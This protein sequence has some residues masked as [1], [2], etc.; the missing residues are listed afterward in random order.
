MV[1]LLFNYGN[2]K[3]K[4]IKSYFRKYIGSSWCGAVG[5][6]PTSIHEHVGWSQGL[7]QWVQDL[8]L[9]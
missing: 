6:N 7:A 2:E 5:M 8:V 9:W 1:L 3:K 4:F